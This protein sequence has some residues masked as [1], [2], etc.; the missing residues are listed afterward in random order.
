MTKALQ[1]LQDMC[2][3]ILLN[4]HEIW[5][6]QHLLLVT[7]ACHRSIL[8]KEM[9]LEKPETE[10]NIQYGLNDLLLLLASEVDK[11]FNIGI[12]RVTT[13]EETLHLSAKA[14]NS[15]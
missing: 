5:R 9:N 10:E 1:F 7:S 14:G 11:M 6:L 3:P 4:G 15:A 13:L 12:E 8:C 2:D